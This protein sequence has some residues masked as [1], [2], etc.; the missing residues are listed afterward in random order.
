MA[1]ITFPLGL[2]KEMTNYLDTSA[3][4]ETGGKRH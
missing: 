1:V 4:A 2:Y 3:V